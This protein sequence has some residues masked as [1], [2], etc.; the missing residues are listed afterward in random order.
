MWKQALILAGINHTDN[1]EQ[2]QV[3]SQLQQSHL[4]QQYKTRF[5]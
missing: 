1:I 5:D 3:G 2:E 4:M